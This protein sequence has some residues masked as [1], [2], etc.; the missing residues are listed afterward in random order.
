MLNNTWDLFTRGL[1]F[2]GSAVVFAL[3]VFVVW[4]TTPLRRLLADALSFALIFYVAPWAVYAFFLGVGFTFDWTP[5]EWAYFAVRFGIAVTVPIALYG[6]VPLALDA[7]RVRR[8][9]GVWPKDLPHD[10]DP[11]RMGVP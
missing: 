1:P 7:L 2:L 8:R 3:I 9:Y 11:D 4:T 10:L 5:P 6:L